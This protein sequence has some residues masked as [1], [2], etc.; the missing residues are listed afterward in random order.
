MA[1]MV[2]VIA[3]IFTSPDGLFLQTIYYPLLLHAEHR[4]S[5]ALDAFSESDTFLV[6]GQPVPYVDVAATYDESAGAAYLHLVNLHRTQTARVSVAAGHIQR[7]DAPVWEIAGS[8]P[9]LVNSFAEPD[10][11]GI[12]ERRTPDSRS[13]ELPPLSASTVLI[14]L[15]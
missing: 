13:I 12:R 15:T 5:V 1:Q 3:P 10:N 6:R 4:G 7:T 8:S 11:V 14:R 2:N 9:D